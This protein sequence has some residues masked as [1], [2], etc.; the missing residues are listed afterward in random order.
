MQVKFKDFFDVLRSGSLKANRSFWAYC[1]RGIAAEPP[2]GRGAPLVRA[3]EGD[4]ADS[5]TRA[6][7]KGARSGSPKLLIC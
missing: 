6:R 5:P 3:R 7:P 1:A 4:G 2:S